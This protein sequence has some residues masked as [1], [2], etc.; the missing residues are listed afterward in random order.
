[1]RKGRGG[2]HLKLHSSFIDALE[3]VRD[4]SFLCLMVRDLPGEPLVAQLLQV[5]QFFFKGTKLLYVCQ[6]NLNRKNNKLY[7][8]NEFIHWSS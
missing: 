2:T 6:S 8:R 7:S 1:M 5:I 4:T 3:N